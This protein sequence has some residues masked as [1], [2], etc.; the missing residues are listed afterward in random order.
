MCCEDSSGCCKVWNKVVCHLEQRN[1]NVMFFALAFIAGFLS[2][3]RV[4]GFSQ[5]KAASLSLQRIRAEINAG[6]QA[7]LVEQRNLARFSV[8][9]RSTC[10]CNYRIRVFWAMY[11]WV[12]SWFFVGRVSSMNLK[13]PP[14]LKIPALRRPTKKGLGFWRKLRC[15]I[16]QVLGPELRPKTMPATGPLPS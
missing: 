2:A 9:C 6:K 16:A 12:M 7:Y 11:C 1:S 14:E 8:C 3:Y 5:K 4:E 15:K 13:A 10:A